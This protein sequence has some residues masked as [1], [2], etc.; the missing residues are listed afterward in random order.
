MSYETNDPKGWGGDPARGAALGRP[1]ITPGPPV[2][3]V[4]VREIRL[5]RDGYDY[6]GTYWG[7]GQPLFFAEGETADGE[8]WE[9]TARSRCY[10]LFR[11]RIIGMYGV[12]VARRA[13]LRPRSSR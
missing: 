13:M 6:L 3:T 7:I 8:P 1:D 5:D 2:G 4:T 10:P 12:R 11:N 9:I